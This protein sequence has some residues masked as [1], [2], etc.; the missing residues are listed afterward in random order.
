MVRLTACGILL[1]LPALCSTLA[2]PFPEPATGDHVLKD[3]RFASGET[4]PELA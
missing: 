1:L 2:D 3:F 4:L